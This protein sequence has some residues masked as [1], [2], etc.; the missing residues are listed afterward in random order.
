MSVPGRASVAAKRANRP[1]P[2]EAGVV[3]SWNGTDRPHAAVGWPGRHRNV[4]ATKSISP[5]SCAGAARGRGHALRQRPLL[6]R[7]RRRQGK[8][9]SA[10]RDQAERRW[11]APYPAVEALPRRL[12]FVDLVTWSCWFTNVRACLGT[13]LHR[14]VG[15]LGILQ[16]APD[17]LRATAVADRFGQGRC[18]C[19]TC[20][21][22][23][24]LPVVVADA[25]ARVAV[26]GPGRLWQS[27]EPDSAVRPPSGLGSTPAWAEPRA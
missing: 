2:R 1:D 20:R 25:V 6:T 13:R 8:R 11:Y 14:P 12:P 27:R 22:F 21:A 4:P 9:V 18:C 5:R 19:P 7:P 26:P 23:G 24:A 17:M 16:G 3:G 15:R 10:P